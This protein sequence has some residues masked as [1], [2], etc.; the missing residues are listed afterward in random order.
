MPLNNADTAMEPLTL[1]LS[2]MN[3]T[4]DTNGITANVDSLFNL[5]SVTAATIAAKLHHSD[6][7]IT[8]G[9]TYSKPTGIDP[10]K[11]C[12]FSFY[13]SSKMAAFGTRIFGNALEDAMAYFTA[14]NTTIHING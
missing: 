14:H 11:L 3:F 13:P 7:M 12:V 9:S 2:E 5:E 6:M 1:K 10:G 4:A 8:V